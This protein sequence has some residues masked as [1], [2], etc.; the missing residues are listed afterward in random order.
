MSGTFT[1]YTLNQY[2][3]WSLLGMV[4]A[5]T[6]AIPDM[7]RPYV[8]S[9]T[10][11]RDFVDS[12]YRGYPTGYLVISQ[13]PD[14]RL[15]NG[16]GAHGKQILIDGQQRVT[17]L[18]AALLGWTVRT[19]SYKKTTIKI[20][21]NP[22]DERFEVQTAPILKD[23]RWIA[24]ISLYFSTEYSQ[25]KLF[26]EY[27]KNNPEA[28]DEQ[29]FEAISKLTAIKNRQLG[30]II[31]PPTLESGEVTE[32][33][34]RINSQ[35]K[36]LNEAD[37][38]MSKIAANDDYDGT[39]LRK[40]IDY[41]C[42]LAVEPSF[43]DEIRIDDP[44]FMDTAYATK[45][46]W[47]ANDKK[48]IYDPDYTDMLRVAFMFKF[49]RAK[50]NDL[51][52][53]L[54]G[55][56]FTEKDYKEEIVEDTFNKLSEGVLSFM[57]SYCFSQFTTAIE[58][59]GFSNSKLLNAQMPLNFAYMLFLYLYH[60]KEISKQEIKHYVTR[61]YV[62]SRLTGRYSMS[63]ESRM[64]S[65]LTTIKEHGFLH[66]FN[67]TE[68]AYLTPDFWNTQLVSQLE[69]ASTTSPFFCIYLAAQIHSGDKSL[70]H[71]SVSIGPLISS[72]EVHHIFPKAY[73]KENGI[74]EQR[75]IN[76]IAN[77]TYLDPAI[78]KAIGADAPNKYFPEHLQHSINGTQ[79][80]NI[81]T[82]AGFWQ[83][84][85]KNCIPHSILDMG[86]SSYQQFLSERRKL[87]AEK[88]K[89][90]YYSL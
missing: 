35:G 89:Q 67:E 66:L 27:M 73:L 36:R 83:S 8:W 19:A 53:L 64:N 69:V 51:V 4:S 39:N 88:I 63:P 38:A 18:A 90:Y 21:F 31:L 78:N 42:H 75:F 13:N 5:G 81:N 47:L 50:L 70:L 12:L 24:D 45:M 48:D 72:G 34:V 25:I 79:I 71:S 30:A 9:A 76:Q 43:L 61:W 77:F 28:D 68:S 32:V 6:I 11:V 20:A 46:A 74:T 33:F 26:S 87:M 15:K 16:E 22:I 29:V 82:E 14:I 37:F 56:D 65:D 84:L 3:V 2:T 10:Q 80:G 17:S 49:G 59:I 1:T 23:K 52:S 86:A 55:R 85:D 41:F 44:N 54:S 60:G 7:Q 40:A 62:L 57:D 58:S